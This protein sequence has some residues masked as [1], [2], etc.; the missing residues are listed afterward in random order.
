MSVVSPIDNNLFKKK[1]QN[2]VNIATEAFLQEEFFLLSIR[3]YKYVM[4]RSSHT[5]TKEIGRMPRR[6]FSISRLRK[7]IQ[8]K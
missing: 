7:N 3:R 2:K 8:S 5:E 4:K 6:A 1:P